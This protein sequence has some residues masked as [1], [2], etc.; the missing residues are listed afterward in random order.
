MAITRRTHPLVKELRELRDDPPADVLFLEG[1]KLLQEALQAAIPLRKL[2]VSS[3]VKGH[4]ELLAKAR[5]AAATSTDVAEAVFQSF[6]DVEEPQ[7][8]LAIAERPKWTWAQLFGK[9][10]APVVVLDGLQNP[11]NVA[12]ILRTAEAAGAAG[13]VT[14]PGTARLNSPK[15]LRSAMG[16]SLRMPVFEHL[17]PEAIAERL[18]TA[19]CLIYAAAAETKKAARPATAYTEIDWT[20]AS[21]IVF[22]QESGGVSDK[23]TAYLHRV[24]AIPMDHPVESLNVGAAA[25][26]ILYEA[27]RQRQSRPK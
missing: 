11:G 13:V 2:I 15:A 22:G 1:P 27:F 12:S 14:T 7:G 17:A 9:A 23:W 16:A 20:L 18:S 10:P 19:G 25:A 21:A 4:E 5:A 6:S 24:V 3:N 8:I 26:V